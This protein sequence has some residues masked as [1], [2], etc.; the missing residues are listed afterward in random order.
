MQGLT[1]L[2]NMCGLDFIDAVNLFNAEGVT[3]LWEAV[4]LKRPN[5]STLL[6]KAGAATN[7]RNAN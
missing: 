6:L 2:I 5:M 4:R 1:N 3:P 7:L